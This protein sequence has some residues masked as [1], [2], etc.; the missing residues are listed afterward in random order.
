MVQRLKLTVEYDGS[1]FQGWQR[2][3]DVPSVQAVLEEAVAAFDS[4]PEGDKGILVYGAGR[5]DAGVHAYGQ[6]AHVDIYRDM[7]AYAF[8]G[9]MNHFL[10]DSGVS[11]LACEAVPEAFHARFSAVKRHYVY[12]I[13][14][15]VG[16][17][18]VEQSRVWHVRT[19]LDAAAMH[20]AAQ[21]LVGH[22]DFTTFRHVHCQSES[23]VKTLDYL[24]V[25]RSGPYIEV[26]T[27]ARSFLHNQVRSMVGT[28]KLVGQGRWNAADVKAALEAR[29][30]QRLGFNAP[31]DGLYLSEV[32][33]PD[34][35]EII[36]MAARQK[37][38][39][40]RPAA[41]DDTDA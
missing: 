3:D 37:E 15:R 21:Q 14:N 13:L 29:D 12:R 32:T 40:A 17:P 30:R 9:A 26:R 23:P 35:D 20:E 6:V 25:T 11:I 8:M 10:T 28:I 24:D 22:H 19:P 5:T 18:A 2:Q 7:T 27:G 39:Q 38:A 34:M 31:P 33:Y 16:P 4:R 41:T 1:R 36:K